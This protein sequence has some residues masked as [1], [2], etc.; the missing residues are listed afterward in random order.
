MYERG[1]QIMNKNDPE[2]KNG[3][4]LPFMTRDD[5]ETLAMLDL[6]EEATKAAL[7]GYYLTPEQE[8]AID[9]AEEQMIERQRRDKEAEKNG[10]KK[11]NF[12]GPGERLKMIEYKTE[13]G[14]VAMKMIDSNGN[15]VATAVFDK[16]F[17]DEYGEDLGWKKNLLPEKERME[18]EEKKLNFHVVE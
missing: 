18:R 5:K 12:G 7:L 4:I 14:G 13:D 15:A 6:V 8:Y 3:Q 11:E 17:V 16:Q 9:W 10:I 1:D 2:N